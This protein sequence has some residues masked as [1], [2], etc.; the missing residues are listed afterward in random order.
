[1]GLSPDFC[2]SDVLFAVADGTMTFLTS[3]FGGLHKHTKP[4]IKR[5]GNRSIAQ[6]CNAIDA[7]LPRRH[8]FAR[9][10]RQKAFEG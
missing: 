10:R 1:M 9:T 4:A 8:Y 7:L 3:L 6:P 5:H 2:P